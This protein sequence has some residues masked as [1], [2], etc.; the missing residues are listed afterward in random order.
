MQNHLHSA[1]QRQ[2]KGRGHHGLG[3]VLQRHV[4]VL[5]GA[6]RPVKVVPFAFLNGHQ[7]QH[8]VRAHAEIRRLVADHHGVEA[9]V[10]ALQPGVNHLHGVSPNGVHLGM[11]LEADHA[12]AEVDQACAGILL[13]FLLAGFERGQQQ[14]AR[15]FCDIAVCAAREIEVA[16]SALA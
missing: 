2:A 12:V 3:R 7:H 1:A 14:D 11:E 4:G 8:Q 5:E 16:S 6:H 10:Q 15:L 9:L 13:D